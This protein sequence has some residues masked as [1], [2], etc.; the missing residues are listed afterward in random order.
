MAEALGTT[1]E[2]V[3]RRVTDAVPADG[4]AG[5]GASGWTSSNG[6]MRRSWSSPRTAET[7]KSYVP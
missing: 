5:D 3:D 2:A 1:Q 4:R 7:L 6:C